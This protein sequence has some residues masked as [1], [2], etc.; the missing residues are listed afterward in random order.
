MPSS[1]LPTTKGVRYILA[2]FCEY[3][4]DSMESFMTLYQPAHDGFGG[5]S[6][7]KTGDIIRAIGSCTTVN[8]QT[9]GVLGVHDASRKVEKSIVLVDYLSDEEWKQ[10][11]TSCELLTPGEDSIIIVERNPALR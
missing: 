2:G 5:L 9:V 1:A 8:A 10:H 7:C 4:D 11:A 3:G 6:G